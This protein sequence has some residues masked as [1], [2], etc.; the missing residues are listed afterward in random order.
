M[1]SGVGT[2]SLQYPHLLAS[3]W[4]FSETVK[5]RGGAQAAPLLF[6]VIVFPQMDPS[7]WHLSSLLTSIHFVCV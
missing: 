4:L 5:F 1:D 2:S 3:F 6:Q 7:F